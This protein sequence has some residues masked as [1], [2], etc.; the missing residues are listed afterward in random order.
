MGYRGKVRE[1]EEARRLRAENRTLADIAEQL[2]VSK[3]SVS[4]WVRDVPFTPSTRRYGPQRRP[5]PAQERK[6]REIDECNQLGSDLLGVLD[7]EAFLA[8]GV[9]LYAGEGTKRDGSVVF[10]N[11]DDRMMSFFCAWLR[12]FFEIDECR[13]RMRVYL[14]EGLDL[15]IAE[16]HS[17]EIT[18]IPLVQ[19]RRAYR[20]PS[21]AT[22]R[23]NKHEYGCAYVSYTCSRTHRRIMGLIRALLS[24][25]SYSGVAQLVAQRPVKPTVVGSSPTPGAHNSNR[26]A[27][28]NREPPRGDAPLP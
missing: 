21:D 28:R 9:A 24:S 13:L 26:P 19:F 14:H 6:F 25:A 3:S 23:H 4:L 2:G 18:G 8:A 16:D 11:T 1:R 20:A 5:H 12:A 7:E 17:S 27:G 10:S 22:I 15:G